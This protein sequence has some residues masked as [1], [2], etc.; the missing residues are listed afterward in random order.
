MCIGI[1]ESPHLRTFLG[2]PTGLFALTRPISDSC[3][4]AELLCRGGPF[5]DLT[6]FPFPLFEGRFL[7]A[8]DLLFVG[9]FCKLNPLVQFLELFSVCKPIGELKR[10][11]LDY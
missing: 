1:L 6:V 2:L 11:V 9:M 8:G 5:H 3:P 4:A 10:M 7:L